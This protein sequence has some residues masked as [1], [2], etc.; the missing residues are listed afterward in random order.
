MG[1]HTRTRR[2]VSG[3]SRARRRQTRDQPATRLP[4]QGCRVNQTFSGG[5][6][7]YL[8]LPELLAANRARGITLPR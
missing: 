6:A 3:L 4:R 8:S 7:R 5:V 1:R 2:D